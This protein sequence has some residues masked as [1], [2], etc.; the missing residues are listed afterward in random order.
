MRRPE[1][2][3]GPFHAG[4]GVAIWLN[5]V[6]TERGTRFFRSI[7]IAPRRYRDAATGIWKSAT[8]FR[9]GDLTTLTLALAEAH[10]YVTSTPLPG[11]AMDGDEYQ[12]MQ[13]QEDGELLEESPPSP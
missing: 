10:R 1:R 6:E 5:S 7:T 4:L 8:S 13:V 12:D 2:K 11:Q 3:I 9:P